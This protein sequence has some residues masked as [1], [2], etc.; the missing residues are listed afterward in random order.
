MNANPGDE[1]PKSGKKQPK[2]DD[3]R[4]ATDKERPNRADMF[5]S[6]GAS[7]IEGV[8]FPET[9]PEEIERLGNGPDPSSPSWRDEVAN[10]W[11]AYETPLTGYVVGRMMARSVPRHHLANGPIGCATFWPR[12]SSRQP[13]SSPGR[14]A[15]AVFRTWIKTP[16]WWHVENCLRRESLGKQRMAQDERDADA[17]ADGGK[18][19]KV[20]WRRVE[21]LNSEG[22]PEVT[23]E[24]AESSDVADELDWASDRT[25]LF[26]LWI[27][28]FQLWNEQDGDWKRWRLF[29]KLMLIPYAQDQIAGQEIA[30]GEAEQG[31]GA[32]QADEPKPKAAKGK[33]QINQVYE[34]CGYDTAGRAYYAFEK[35]RKDFDGCVREVLRRQYAVARR[36]RQAEVACGGR[37]GVGRAYRRRLPAVSPADGSRNRLEP[38]VSRNRRTGPA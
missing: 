24:A 18:K 33:T 4:P 30:A 19:G 25:W 7:L 9:K 31:D 12:I 28:A 14:K 38:P 13:C 5:L 37:G 32:D 3:T 34:E 22:A 2:P 6:S 8:L 20:R 36:G 15:G 35:F 17:E 21:S 23:D 10:F 26:L 11:Q 27:G 1:K 16:C 29:S